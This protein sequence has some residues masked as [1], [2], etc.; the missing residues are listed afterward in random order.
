MEITEELKNEIGNAIA[1]YGIVLRKASL[2][3]SV[4]HFEKLLECPLAELT[5]KLQILKE[6]H[7]QL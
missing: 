7:K 4:P 1:A 2:G 6:F 3:V 5:H